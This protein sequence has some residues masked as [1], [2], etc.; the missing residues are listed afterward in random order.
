MPD[1]IRQFETPEGPV[2]IN[3]T[4]VQYVWQHEGSAWCEIM[5]AGRLRMV[6][7]D[8]DDLKAWIREFD[9]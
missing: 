9:R 2:K 6:R 1:D 8:A 7:A 4:Q 5:Y 3:R